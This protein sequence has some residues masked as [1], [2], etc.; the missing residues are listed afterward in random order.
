MPLRTDATRGI[1]PMA[2]FRA[3]P[4]YALLITAVAV[5]P[6]RALPPRDELLRLVPEDVGFCLVVQD[7]RGHLDKVLAS[8]CVAQ[9][10]ASPLGQTVAGAPETQKLLATAAYFR[11]R[12][13]ID[14]NSLR[15]DILGDAVVLAYWPGPDGK[16]ERERGVALVRAGNVPALVTLMERLNTAQ[17]EAG[18]PIRTRPYKGGEYVCWGEDKGAI[19]YYLRG[20]VLAVSQHEETL[21]RIIERDRA[22]A[23]DEEPALTGRLRRLGLD[24][25]LAALWI[26]PRAFEAEIERKAAQAGGPEAFVLNSLLTYWKSLDGIAL[27]GTVGQTDLE[28]GL[29]ILV[30]PERLPAPAR[31]LLVKEIRPSA[32]WRYFPDNALLAVGGRV[33]AVALTELVSG[34]LPE[35]TRKTLGETIHRGADAVIDK[36]V[37]RDVLPRLG[38]DWGFCLLAP[39]QASKCWVPHLVAALRIQPGDRDPPLDRVALEALNTLSILGV[40]SYNAGHVDQISLKTVL[41][42]KI[43]IKYLANDK[44]FLAGFQPAYALKEGFL[45]L[46][47]SPDAIRAFRAI[48]SSA[49]AGIPGEIPILRVS[50][51]EIRRYLKERAGDLVPY[52]AEKDGVSKEEAGRRLGAVTSALE[53]VDRLEVSQR[54]ST[55]QVT[56][57][58]RL[59]PAQPL[60]K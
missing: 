23:K 2:R 25:N 39:P 54:S 50:F 28:L 29:T 58:L 51:G 11:E 24:K 10:R 7:L 56:L 4:A 53:L 44:R 17:K 37:M 59:R 5:A 52:L 15:N 6:V 1:L 32:L 14:W 48:P 27:F 47:S 3:W 35:E 60:S 36:D 8:P 45:V 49:P 16:E 13:K 21:H 22:A 20:P 33:D 57:I 12:L 26:N 19:Y 55:N 34:F 46:A 18:T 42:D 41:W 40:L 30:N 38:P 31:K 9:W 43:E